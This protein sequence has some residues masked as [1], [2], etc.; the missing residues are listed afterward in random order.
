MKVY[1]VGGAVRDSLLNLPIKDRDWV[2]VGGTKEILLKKNFQQVGKDFPVFLHPETHEEYSLA[3]KER[4]SGRGYTG[5]HTEFSSDVTLEEDLIRR[6]LTINAIAQDENG[7]YID[8]FQG[9]KDLN[10][11]LLRHVSESFTED[12]LR[13]LRT[14]RFAANLMHLGFHIDKDTMILMCKMVKKNELLYLTKNRIWNETEKAFKT[15]NPH[16]YFQ[17]LHACKALNFIFPEIFFLYERRTF[18]SIL[19]TNFYSISFLSIGLSKISTLTK[20]VSIRFSY[21]CQFLSEKIDFSSTKENYDDDSAKLV[22]KLCKRCNIP[23]HIEELAVLNTGF[24]VFLSSIHYQSSSNIIKMFSKI[25]AWRKPDRIYKLSFLCDFNLFYHQ[26]KIDNSKLK[27]GFLKKCFFI[28]K[29]I[30]VKKIL[31]QGF[32][33]YQIKNELNKLRVNKLKFWRM[34]KKCFFF[35]E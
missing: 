20:D 35:K 9:R 34:K 33:G 14:A 3:R 24:C 11:R 13:I 27:T 22:K 1:L 8:P 12:P 32:K 18:F 19:F 2:I 10:L 28:I 25:D 7:N 31:N 5:F 29:D 21:L 16:V 17:I 26:N 4:K 15:L 23:S 6:D 30:S